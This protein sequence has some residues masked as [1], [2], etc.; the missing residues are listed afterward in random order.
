MRIIDADALIAD[1]QLA[2]KQA[3]RHGREY[4]NAFY[5]GG[6]EISTEWWCVEDMIENA[7]TIEPE[8]KKGR[9][10]RTDAY[11]HRRYCSVCFATFIRNDEFLKLDDIPHKYCPNCGA[12]M[13][14]DT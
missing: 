13:G 10:M 6:G 11:P 12:Y 9:W 4:A 5:S 14:G 7:P 8:R 3:D 2:Q 1:C